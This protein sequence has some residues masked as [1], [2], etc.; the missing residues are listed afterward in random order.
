MSSCIMVLYEVFFLAGVPYVYPMTF[1][2][3]KRVTA[4][5]CNPLFLL[6]ERQ[7]FEPWVRCRTPDFESGTID[8]SDTSPSGEPVYPILTT[9]SRPVFKV[10]N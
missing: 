7:G 1:M 2:K 9:I 5:R 8:H 4:C 10:I 6:A 3:N